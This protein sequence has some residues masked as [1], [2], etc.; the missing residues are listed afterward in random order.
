LVQEAFVRLH[1]TWG[2][3]DQP[4]AYL[5]TTVVNR[6]RSWQR[7]AVMERQRQP[8]PQ[9]V[10]VVDA[11]VR[12]LLDAVARL[13]PR[14]RAAVVLR[15]YA[16]LSEADIARALRCRPGTVKSLIHRGLRQLEGMIER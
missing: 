3:A 7:R 10:V 1:R 14:R 6:C 5:R 16:D 8:R 11:E 15:F 9:A 4:A 13:G 12:E 2:R